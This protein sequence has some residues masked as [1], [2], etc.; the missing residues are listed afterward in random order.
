LPGPSGVPIL[1]NL[2]QIKVESMHLILEEWFRQYG[3]LY[4]IKLGPDRTLVVG[5]PD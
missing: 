5:D 1:G 3:D 2:H 4:Q